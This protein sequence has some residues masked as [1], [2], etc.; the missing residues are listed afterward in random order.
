[1]QRFWLFLRFGN[2]AEWVGDP[3]HQIIKFVSG[4]FLLFP[5]AQGRRPGGKAPRGALE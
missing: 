4:V 3:K 2:A 1:M 5:S